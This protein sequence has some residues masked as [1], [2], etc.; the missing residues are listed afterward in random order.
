MSSVD[1]GI[2]SWEHLPPPGFS[3]ETALGEGWQAT[4]RNFLV[5]MGA[6][7]VQ[8][9]LVASLAGLLVIGAMYAPLTAV[10]ILV[11]PVVLF[12]GLLVAIL[13]W[14]LVQLA[15][16]CVDGKAR[17]SL[18]FS[19]VPQ[20]PSILAPVLMLEVMLGAV[21]VPGVALYGV[22]GLVQSSKPEWLTETMAMGSVT[23]GE[24]LGILGTLIL[25]GWA[26]SIFARLIFAPSRL[27]DV[28]CSAIDA[29]RWSWAA[30]KPLPGTAALF[31]A[32]LA[33]FVAVGFCVFGIGIIPA[34]ITILLAVGSAYRQL[35]RTGIH[36][37]AAPLPD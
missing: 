6:I 1:V 14:G 28:R 2:E 4:K 11:T 16:G 22:V 34:F 17:F 36:A 5:L 10:K 15:L 8:T 12:L 3:I 35:S 37:L 30:T 20:A 13:G 9:L 23:R 26:L 29:L 21:A 25:V 19:G 18:A 32:S 24:L 31:V 7:F 33:F 27:V